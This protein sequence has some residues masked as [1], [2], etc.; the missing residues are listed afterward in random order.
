MHQ[1]SFPY[2]WNL[3]EGYPAK[4]IEHH[5]KR[6]FSCFACGGGSTMG[7]KLAGF[8]V[9]GA[10]EFVEEYAECYQKN[11]NPKYL[12]V[13]DIRTFRK[14]Q[15]LPSE[16]FDLDILDGSPPCSAFSTAGKREQ[17]W[18]IEKNYAQGRK[19][20][21]VDD[22][23]FEF[24]EL[25]KRLQPKV[26]VAENVKGLISGNAK[27]YCK[28]IKEAFIDAGYE[29]QLFLLNA[30]TMGVPQK[31]ERVFFVARRKDLKLP[32]LKLSFNEKPILFKEISDESDTSLKTTT[33]GAELW[34]I[35]KQGKDFSSVAKNKNSYF[36]HKKMADNETPYTI[37]A[38]QGSC[39]W[40]ST[41]Q[42]LLNKTELCQIGSYPLDYDFENL[43]PK[44]L[45]GRSVPPVMMAQLS[46][47]IYLQ[48]F[49]NR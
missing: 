44:E 27:I 45:I 31:R 42:R 13:E 47:Q 34:K 16:L 37:I 33:G 18:G 40:H 38:A 28:K 23:Y 11:H 17:G 12:F 36:S 35:C 43:Q 3:S 21:V 41:I 25:V 8:D 22:L 46:Y 7:Y 10:N 6:V 48:F 9:I 30:S 15:D 19:K 4:N 49:K 32:E 1:V 2:K 29:I 5:K 24:I 26:V 39:S 14:K 20:Q